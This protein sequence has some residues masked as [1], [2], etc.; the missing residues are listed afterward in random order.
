VLPGSEGLAER[1]LSERL[2]WLFRLRNSDYDQG[3]FRRYWMPDS[4]GRECYECQVQRGLP[5]EHGHVVGQL[6]K[7]RL[8]CARV[9]DGASHS[10]TKSVKQIRTKTR[11]RCAHITWVSR[12]EFQAVKFFNVL[13][14]N[15]EIFLIISDHF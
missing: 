11:E 2:S 1:R 4:T 13:A 9:A 6:R 3:D 7:F 15:R 10:F 14:Q 12:F 8:R 5:E